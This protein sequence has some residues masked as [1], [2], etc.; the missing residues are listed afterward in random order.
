ME[1][2]LSIRFVV[3]AVYLS[4]LV[5][6]LQ[7]LRSG[8]KRAPLPS[9][10]LGTG[11]ALHL[12]E[13]VLRGAESGAAGGAPFA[14][15]SGFLSIFAFLLGATYFALERHYR[16]YRISSLGAFHVPVLFA[17]HLWSV[18]LRQPIFDIPQL[19]R[20][21]LFIAHVVPTIFAYAALTAGFVAGVAFLI[22]D[23][24][25]RNK[26][27]DLLMRGLPNLDLVERVNASAVKI[28][29]PL[30]AL[31]GL[32][33]LIMGYVEWGWAYQW[34]YKVWTTIG[35]VVIFAA[36]LALRRYAGWNGRRA[37]LISMVGFL[38]IVFN[39]TVMNYFY[40]KLHSF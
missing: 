29:L 11:I 4:A 15:M 38:A 26:R 39:A 34:D 18:V 19:N 21:W 14:N 32:L 36:Q 10:L 8:R 30:V 37:I 22:L 7:L 20:G 27:F 23:R 40:S 1:T 3:S 31:G 35:I 24:Q 6:Y 13:V 2:L 25:L 9:A 12:A 33:G 17:L 16:K 28:G 5:A